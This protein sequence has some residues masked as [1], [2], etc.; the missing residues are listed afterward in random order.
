[1]KTSGQTKSWVLR[2]SSVKIAIVLGSALLLQAGSLQAVPPPAGVAPVNN[3]MGGFGIDGNLIANQPASGVGDWLSLPGVS[4]SGG[5][6]LGLGGNPLNPDVTFHF[7]DVAN[8]SG[9]DNIFRSGKWFDD[10]SSW[11]WTMGKCSS[12]TD[13]NNVLLHVTTD[14]FGHVWMVIAADR[15]SVNG[16]SYI[17]F[18]FLQN[19]LVKNNDHTFSS[20]GPDGGR[21]VN[22]L[23]LSLAFT[24]GGSTADFYA[25]RWVPD[26]SSGFTYADATAS[27]P[28]GKVFVALNSTNTPVPYGAFGSTNYQANAFAEAAIDLTALLGNLDPCLTFSVKTIMVKTKASASSTASIEDFID[29][30]QYNIRIGPAAD[31]GPDQTVCDL[32]PTNVFQLN[33]AASPGIFPIASNQWSVVSGDA[34]IDSPGSLSTLVS[35]TSASATLRLTVTQSNGCSVFDDVLLTVASLPQASIF[36]PAQADPVCPRGQFQLSGPA[37]MSS[38]NW[39]I[40]GN[41]SLAGAT[42][43]QIAT[44]V[45][46]T[47]CGQPLTVTLAVQ[48]ASSC[49]DASSAEYMV[50]DVTPPVL[51]LP[52]D[53]TL[54]FP[55][56]T[57]TNYTGVATASDTCGQVTIS[58]SDAVTAGCGATKT[59]TRTWTA[60][61]ACGNS[62]SRAQ[63]IVVQD[64]TAP[65]ITIP[66]NLTFEC[67]GVTSTNVTGTA[68]ATDANGP[69]TIRYS[70]MVTNGPCG[71]AKKITRTWTAT[72]ACGNSSSGVQLLNTVDTTPPNLQVPPDLVLEYPANTGTN[73][74]GVPIVYDGCSQVTV[75]YV[76]AVTNGCG[77][78]KSITRTWTAVDECGNSTNGVQHIVVRDTTAPT[79]TCPAINVQCPGDVP[80]PYASLAAFL[81]AGGKATDN[82]T[83]TLSFALISDSGL[84]GSCPGKVTRVYQV[85]DDCGNVTQATQIINVRDTIAPTII[86]PGATTVEC[87]SGLD[88]A[89]LGRATA[90]DNCSPNVNITYSDTP[91]S[92]QYNVKWYAADPDSGTGPYLPTYLKFAPANLPRPS[93]A[94]LTGRAIDPLRNAVA[95]ASPG[96]QLDALTSLD[97]GNLTMGQVVPFEAVIEASGGPGPEHGTIQF[98]ATWSTYTTSNDRFG[99]DT[100]YMVYCAFVDPADPGTIDP[101]YNARVESY[102]SVLIN[103]GTIDEKIQ[104]T[105]RVSGIE[106][107]DRVVVEIWVVLAPA[108]PSHAGGTI[109]SALVSAQT[110]AVPPAPISVGVQTVSI[111]SLSK[112][113]STLPPPQ[114]QPPPPSLP[115]QPPVLPGVTL[116]VVDRTWA[117]TDDCGNRSTC[118]QRITVRDSTPPTISYQPL[119]TLQCGDATDPNTIGWA[120]AVDSCGT[121]TLGYTDYTT[122]LCGGCKMIERTWLATDQWGNSTNVVQTITMTDTTP[123][124]FLS[125]PN[126]IMYV[127][128]P[129]AMTP[130]LATDA[131]S[132]VSVYLSSTVTNAS[133]D[134][135]YTIACTWEAMDACGNVAT[136]NNVILVLPKLPNPGLAIAMQEGLLSLQWPSDPSG[137]WL[138]STVSLAEPRWHPVAITPVLT[139]GMC[140]V[141]LVPTGPSQ[142]FRLAS[143]TPPLSLSQSQ[144]GKLMLTWPSLATGYAVLRSDNPGKGPW[145]PDAAIIFVTNGMNCMEFTPTG[146]SGFFK[147]VKPTP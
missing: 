79:V 12:K 102:S 25:Y 34:T 44:V 145:L 91:V 9:G 100:N 99:Y 20:Q 48:N 43:Q 45:A 130:P 120:Q 55:A 15:Y 128:D 116:N 123:P 101:N 77:S 117:A 89:I 8:V 3:P 11:T 70:D 21:T 62:T 10:P 14:A 41:G 135:S 71:G 16:S 69:V 121:V 141:T 17:D 88:P 37:G 54:E 32:G 66:Q 134:G 84:V 137:W 86:C 112:M 108:M 36:G 67:P 13:L 110:A 147:L 96:G 40:A 124:E 5:A 115:P 109:A 113:A 97:A 83:N 27:L 104:G 26:G 33:G 139:N 114:T 49:S 7:L 64:T 92:S 125:E 24:S 142:W 90:T 52:P 4:G 59:I 143:G 50:L 30:I 85:T 122:S 56:N 106:S 51:V 60:V 65:V 22:D 39:S 23:L 133:P 126:S 35:V 103:K 72:D 58:Y 131:C 61:D 94:A 118:V 80:A 95:Y 107:G 132:Q 18:E 2:T 119:V 73:A 78:S 146:G 93:S 38:Y 140:K 74:T 98:T 57:G 68:T 129:L 6:V 42:N 144:P 1:M 87:G 46:G 19:K 111:G 47:N 76:D 53:I 63:K 127:G 31:A 105:F 75:S 81:A 136:T 29:P 82:S 28:V 138:E